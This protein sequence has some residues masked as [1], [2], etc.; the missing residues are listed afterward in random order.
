MIRKYLISGSTKVTFLERSNYIARGGQPQFWQCYA[1]L[2]DDETRFK[3]PDCPVEFFKSK[4]K[5]LVFYDISSVEKRQIMGGYR[6]PNMFCPSGTGI[7]L[8]RARS[9]TN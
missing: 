3:T 5:D 4:Y 9:R 1:H 2:D 8:Q 7:Q 6:A